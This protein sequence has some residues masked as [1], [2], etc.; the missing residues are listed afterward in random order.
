M[1]WVVCVVEEVAREDGLGCDCWVMTEWALKAE[2]KEERNGRLVGIFVSVSVFPF[3]VVDS[4]LR[5]LPVGM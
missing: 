2:R 5:T 4:S 3:R 1:V